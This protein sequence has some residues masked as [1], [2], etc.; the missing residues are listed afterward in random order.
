MYNPFVF[1]PFINIL[2]VVITIWTIIWKAYAVWLAVK[3]SHKKWFLA[4]IILN[5][6][7]LLEIFYV[8]KI[9]K[10]SWTQVKQDFR[11][12]WRSIK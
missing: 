10:K 6:V 9:A 1:S 2:F 5:T 11:H 8:F 4:L 7:G 12:A 3:H